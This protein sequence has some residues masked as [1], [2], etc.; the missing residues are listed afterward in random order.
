MVKPKSE[1]GARNRPLTARVAETVM[2][3]CVCLLIVH[4]VL[5]SHGGT[6]LKYLVSKTVTKPRDILNIDL[7]NCD[8]QGAELYVNGV[9]LGPLPLVMDQAEF[10]NKVPVW[11]EVPAPL[12]RSE[13]PELLR[14][15]RPFGGFYA[16]VHSHFNPIRVSIKSLLSARERAM[17]LS[18]KDGGG[19]G[20]RQIAK[21]PGQARSTSQT[22][23]GK[24][25]LDTEEQTYYAQVKYQGQW[26]YATGSG[27]GGGRN[28]EIHVGLEFICPEYER[29]LEQ[30][31]D[32]ARIKNHRVS[33]A[34]FE[35]LDTFGHDGVLALLKAGPEAPGMTGLLDQW[36]SQAFGLNLVHD[37]VTAWQAFE[38]I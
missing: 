22:G 36:A 33:E 26:C 16:R 15:Y 25:R 37:Q 32:I 7:E 14:E 28:R 38:R 31:L 9:C 6:L 13:I 29:K 21:E 17:L 12:N 23:P 24:S 30:L 8:L 20:G 4:T 10:V 27:S 19:R 11:D 18:G 2:L 1:L 5:L 34:W 3:L 35:A